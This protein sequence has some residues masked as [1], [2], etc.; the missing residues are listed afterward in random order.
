MKTKLFL[1][2]ILS[3]ALI[4]VVV[5]A[6][7]KDSEDDSWQANKWKADELKT[8]GDVKWYEFIASDSTMYV[9]VQFPSGSNLT[10]LYVQL[11]N[12]SKESIN[13]KMEMDHNHAN[14]TDSASWSS[15]SKG[16][17]YYFKVT[18]STGNF[19]DYRIA[20]NSSGSAP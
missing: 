8:D 5:L 15:L 3:L 6:G 17:K 12:S 9:Y 2:G 18:P 19:G 20:Y 11:C 4:F 10:S 1:S 7:C 14:R 13:D 16:T